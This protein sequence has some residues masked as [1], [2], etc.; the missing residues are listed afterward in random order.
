M[1]RPACAVPWT[2][3]RRLAAKQR[4]VS[5]GAPRAATGQRTCAVRSWRPPALRKGR[6]WQLEDQQ[7][8]SMYL[9]SG[10]FLLAS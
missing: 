3:S 1:Q 4:E 5:L 8:S 6:T 10:S 9:V 7:V 2:F